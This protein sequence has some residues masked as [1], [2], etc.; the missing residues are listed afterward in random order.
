MSVSKAV[1]STGAGNEPDQV[2]V[3]DASALLRGCPL[4]PPLH[5]P[6]LAMLGHHCDAL[7]RLRSTATSTDAPAKLDKIPVHEFLR[8]GYGD[9]CRAPCELPLL[10]V[11]DVRSPAEF[12]RGTC[13][14]FLLEHD[15]PYNRRLQAFWAC[16]FLLSPV[17]GA[18]V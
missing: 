16:F 2:C 8:A 12:R 17:C 15:V 14:V 3:D 13:P 5:A 1:I 9:E 10:A 4:P 18:P 11:L 7:A 6:L